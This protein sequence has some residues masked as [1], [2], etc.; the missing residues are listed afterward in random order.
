MDV[1][2][3][4]NRDENVRNQGTSMVLCDIRSARHLKMRGNVMM[5]RTLEPRVLVVSTTCMHG[6]RSG[7]DTQQA[8]AP[9]GTA[10]N[11]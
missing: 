8:V 3:D 4:R 1:D 11:A 5:W 7:S 9:S 6:L 10:G 2:R